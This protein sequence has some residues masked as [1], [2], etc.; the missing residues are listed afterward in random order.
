VFAFI[1]G[2]FMFDD[3]FRTTLI[4]LGLFLHVIHH[5]ATSFGLNFALRRLRVVDEQFDV[6]AEQFVLTG[7]CFLEVVRDAG[8]SQ[9]G[10][11]QLP[12]Y[13]RAS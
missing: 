10:I 4:C 6:A 3:H 9:D 8:L 11:Q 13:Q 1:A 5:V 7:D 12:R 2:H